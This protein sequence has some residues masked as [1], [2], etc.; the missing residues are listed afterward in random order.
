MI[1]IKEIGYYLYMQEQE[2]KQKEEATENDRKLKI[3]G[4]LGERE[5]QESAEN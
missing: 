3:A 2:E 5:K 1:D 4:T